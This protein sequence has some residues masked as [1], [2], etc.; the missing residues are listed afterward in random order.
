MPKVID[1]DSY[2]FWHCFCSLENLDTPLVC[3]VIAL[4]A[5]LQPA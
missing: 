2:E 4:L 3:V 1:L 5:I